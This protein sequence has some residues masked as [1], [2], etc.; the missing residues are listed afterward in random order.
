[1]IEPTPKKPASANQSG[2]R[3]AQ[4]VNVISLR[5]LSFLLIFAGILMYLAQ[6]ACTIIVN[7]NSLWRST[8]DVGAGIWCGMIIGSSGIISHMAS[9]KKTNAWVR[10]EYKM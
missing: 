10:P 1:M 3:M 5:T 8:H 4:V 9:T 7:K 2:T 6:F